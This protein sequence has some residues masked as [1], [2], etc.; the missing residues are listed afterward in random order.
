[1]PAL[2]TD[3]L[4]ISSGNATVQRCSMT[5]L[6]LR[7]GCG[8]G[9]SRM[10][11]C[12]D[13]PVGS[14]AR[15]SV[16]ERPSTG[17]PWTQLRTSAGVG[18][19]GARRAFVGGARMTRS[20]SRPSRRQEARRSALRMLSRR[21]QGPEEIGEMTLSSMGARDQ[22]ETGYSCPYDTRPGVLPGRRLRSGRA[23]RRAGLSRRRRS[24]GRRSA[25]ERS[26]SAVDIRG[27]VDG[28]P[29]SSPRGPGRY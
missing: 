10:S 12:R 4:E 28:W 27:G 18:A 19:G 26:W 3:A 13:L 8:P 11:R 21:R 5:R 22:L 15:A 6:P 23:F 24:S 20:L 7:H 2:A 1:M 17:R 9:A 14:C 16:A 29:R 25:A